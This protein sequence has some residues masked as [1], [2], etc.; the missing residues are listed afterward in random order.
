MNRVIL[1]GTI[2]NEPEIRATSGGK[3]VASFRVNTG[4][5][6]FTVTA[7]EDL[8]KDL[9]SKG[10]YVLVDGRLSTRSYEDKDK[11]KV[12]V[13]EVVASSIETVG[14]DEPADDLGF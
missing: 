11:R 9:P 1:G 14:G 4:K 3:S 5:G 6:W 8:A 12:W 2:D 13:T 10:T 7:W